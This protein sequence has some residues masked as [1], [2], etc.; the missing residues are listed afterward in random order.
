MSIRCHVV[1]PC[2]E[3]KG[4]ELLEI[5]RAGVPATREFPGNEGVEVLSDADDPDT[6]IHLQTWADRESREA[7]LAHLDEAGLTGTIGALMTGPWRSTYLVEHPD[8]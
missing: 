4:P 5:F 8:V 1:F 6:L 3:G 2:H 7:Y